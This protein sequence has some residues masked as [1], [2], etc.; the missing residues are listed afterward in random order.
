MKSLTTLAFFVA[1]FSYACSSSRNTQ[2]TD[3]LYYSPGSKSNAAASS[4]NGEYYNA[5]P[6]DQY[7]MMKAQDPNRWSTFD[8]Y[9]Y[10]GFY[11]PYFG[12]SYYPYILFN[13]W[14]YGNIYPNYMSHYYWGRYS[15]YMNQNYAF[16][17]G[18]YGLNSYYAWNTSYNPYYGGMIVA[19]PQYP[20][21]YNSYATL[22]PFTVRAYG[23]GINI[24]NNSGRFYTPTKADNSY[25]NKSFNRN[26]PAQRTNNFNNSSGSQPAR[27]SFSPSSFGGGSRGGGGFSRGGKG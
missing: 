7:L 19:S 5:N 26:N 16:G 20:S 6:N 2:S 14:A 24:N 12:I 1:V 15:Y 18:Y 13:T 17:N 4:N 23:K 9:S 25:N 27:S 8:D 21:F 11:T 3:D 22:H 10:D